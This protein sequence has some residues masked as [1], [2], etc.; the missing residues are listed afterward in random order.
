MRR[1][2]RGGSFIVC[3]L[4]NLLLNLHWAIPAVIL[5]V[6]HFWLGWSIW[7][8]WGALALW[9]VANILMMLFMGWVSNCDTLPKS[10][11][12]PQNTYSANGS[13]TSQNL[14]QK[15]KSILRLI[16]VPSQKAERLL[17]QAGIPYTEAVS[18]NTNFLPVLFSAL[19]KE[20]YVFYLNEN[21]KYE[22]VACAINRSAKRYGFPLSKESIAFSGE[23]PAPSGRN[24]AERIAR[25]VKEWR[26]F[27]IGDGSGDF[28]A[29]VIS[30]KNAEAFA[31]GLNECFAL[32]GFKAEILNTST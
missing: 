10:S 16:E 27:L 28:Y 9:I 26:V 3:L 17:E 15:L 25:N 23:A 22:N 29:G 12:R 18:E 30:E 11:S 21:E 2:N 14:F 4:I 24:A 31:N 19:E 32:Y 7:W 5:F 20:S 13:N 1:T 8:A 6:L